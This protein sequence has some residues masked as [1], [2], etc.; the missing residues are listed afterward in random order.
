MVPIDSE[1][2]S[3]NVLE[4]A[5]SPSILGATLVL[6]ELLQT[7]R[8]SLNFIACPVLGLCTIVDPTAYGFGDKTAE[9][10]EQ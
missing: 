2:R 8:E 1:L 6:N 7:R 9:L 3:L 4:S 5:R 10:V